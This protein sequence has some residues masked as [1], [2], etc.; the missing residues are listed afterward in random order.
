[1]LFK[2]RHQRLKSDLEPMRE[3]GGIRLQIV[4]FESKDTHELEGVWED[5]DAFRFLSWTSL[6]QP[7]PV[8]RPRVWL[9]KPCVHAALLD[10]LHILANHL[11]RSRMGITLLILLNFADVDARDG[12][13]YVGPH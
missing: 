10:R 5:S 11:L 13:R 7:S 1:M 12:Q 3:S 6:T 4:I 9:L 8:E 2:P